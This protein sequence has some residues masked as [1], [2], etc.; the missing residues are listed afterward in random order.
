MLTIGMCVR[1]IDAHSD[2][3]EIKRLI[4]FE[5]KGQVVQTSS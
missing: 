2:V 5:G 4:Y 3:L 1:K